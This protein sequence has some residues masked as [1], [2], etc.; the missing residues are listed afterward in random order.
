MNYLSNSTGIY[1]RLRQHPPLK[2]SPH[3]PRIP[4]E[5]LTEV[6]FLYVNT[7]NAESPTCSAT[8]SVLVALVCAG[9]QT[10]LFCRHFATCQCPQKPV[11]FF[12]SP[13]FSHSWMQHHTMA[14]ELENSFYFILF[15][16]TFVP[17]CLVHTYP[18]FP[19]FVCTTKG[20]TCPFPCRIISKSTSAGYVIPFY[21]S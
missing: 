9:E 10:G 13:T 11:C 8:A 20:W 15:S 19:T 18:G 7:G 5:A 16:G 21:R 3:L 2:S 1:I 4:K 6:K 17:F 14:D 12:P